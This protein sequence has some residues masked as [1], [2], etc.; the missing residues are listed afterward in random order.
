MNCSFFWDVEHC[1]LL[2][3]FFNPE[4]AGDVF[5]RNGLLS[6]DYTALYTRK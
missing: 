6:T 2:K 5:L 3:F 4:D 1:R